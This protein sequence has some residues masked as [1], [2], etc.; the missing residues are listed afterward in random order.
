MTEVAERTG[1][2]LLDRN[3]HPT[4]RPVDDGVGQ[5]VSDDSLRIHFSDVP[6]SFRFGG[7]RNA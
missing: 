2:P 7:I 6:A 4:L 3:P 1:E 5:Q